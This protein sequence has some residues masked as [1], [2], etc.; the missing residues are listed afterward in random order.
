MNI[1]LIS[2]EDIIEGGYSEVLKF[3]KKIREQKE[4]EIYRLQEEISGII[5]I[6]TLP[7]IDKFVCPLCGSNI[8]R[9][10]YLSTVFGDDKYAEWAANLVTHYRHGHIRYYDLTWKNWR[11]ANKNPEYQC[12]DT[13]E[14]FKEIINNRAKRQLIRAIKKN[15]SKDIAT[16]LIYSFL[17]LQSNDEKT[18]ELIRKNLITLQRRDN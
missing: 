9:S 16:C 15:F 12:S 2:K 5:T 17:K 4:K 7:A 10:D 18:V 1:E 8:I 3:K 6:E 14:D 11:Y 13:H